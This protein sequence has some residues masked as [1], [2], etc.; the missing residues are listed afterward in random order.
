MVGSPQGDTIVGDGSAN[1]LDGGV[2][3]DDLDSGGGGGEAFGGPG[4]D[5]CDGFAIENSCG[6]GSRPARRTAPS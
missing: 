1:R 2:G 5:D 6:A 4:S 3:D